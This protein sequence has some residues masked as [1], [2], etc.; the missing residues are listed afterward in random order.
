MQLA[1]RGFILCFWLI[2]LSAL[3]APSTHA[4]S[5][6]IVLERISQPTIVMTEISSDEAYDPSF[7]KH[8]WSYDTVGH[9]TIITQHADARHITLDVPVHTAAI[10]VQADF[11]FHARRAK[12]TSWSWQRKTTLPDAVTGLHAIKESVNLQAPSAANLRPHG[13]ALEILPLADPFT[14]QRGDRLPIQVL[15]NGKPL[16]HV[17]IHENF[18]TTLSDTTPPTNREGK[19]YATLHADQV[20]VLQLTYEAPVAHDPDVDFMRYNSALTLHLKTSSP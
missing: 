7:L 12:D 20:N 16:P 4:S 5:A 2:S 17:R 19:T 11:G 18:L 1:R 14:R 3:Y 9:P 8:L 6:F 13:L 10:I 15:L